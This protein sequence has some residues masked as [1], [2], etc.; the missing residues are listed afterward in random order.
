VLVLSRI[1][2]SVVVPVAAA[3]AFQAFCNLDRLLHR[4]IYEEASWIEGSPWRVGSRIR[5]VIST[6]LQATILSV[7]TAYD[8]PR[9]VGI[10]NHALGITAEQNATFVPVPKKGTRIL[11]SMDFVGKSPT[12]SDAVIQEA[13]SFLTRD[14]LETIAALCQPGSS[15]SPRQ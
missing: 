9:S 6:P 2:Y 10:L 11:M 5:Y 13:I 7:V 4:G 3:A 14:A 12:I 15:A 1:D 8:P